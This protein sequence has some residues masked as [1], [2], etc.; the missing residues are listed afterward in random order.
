[1]IPRADLEEQ[2][3]P[4]LAHVCCPWCGHLVDAATGVKDGATGLKDGK[5]AIEGNEGNYSVCLYCIGVSKYRQDGERLT[6][7]RVL[8][9]EYVELPVEARSMLR[10]VSRAIQ[11]LHRERAFKR[12]RGR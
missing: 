1:M 6:L 3:D 7:V 11:L 12:G 5:P 4:R 9:D 8:A 2:R 10:R